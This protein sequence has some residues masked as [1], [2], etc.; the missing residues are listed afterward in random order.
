MV[1]YFSVFVLS[2][3]R[4]TQPNPSD[5]PRSLLLA[6][7]LPR[8][9]CFHLLWSVR[10]DD[11]VQVLKFV[12]DAVKAEA[13]NPG[14]LFLFGA[15][16]IGKERLFLEVARALKRKVGPL[17]P[18]GK[19]GGRAFESGMRGRDVCLEIPMHN[20]VLGGFRY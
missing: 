4:R 1:V 14:T 10:W 11:A 17:F 12:I 18:V 9:Q 3:S 20:T 8:F 16:T 2:A 13:F 5:W 19:V 7:V 6:H 15:Y